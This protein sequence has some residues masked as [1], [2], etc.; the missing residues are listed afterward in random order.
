VH[1]YKK[2]DK[3]HCSNY[4]GISLVSTTYKILSN[5]LL[6]TLTPYAEEI[7]GDHQCG[8]Q[9]NRS[10]TVHIFCI[11]QILEKKW[12]YNEVVH[13]LFVDFKKAYDSIRREILY[14]I[15]IEFVIS[16]KLV[17]LVKI[18]LN[19]TYSRVWEGKHLS[20]RFPIKNGLK[21]GEALSPLL[22]NF[23]LEYAI[24]RVQAN[25]KGSKLN[26]MHQLLVYANDVDILGGSIHTIRKNTD[27]LLIA[28]KEIGFEAN[29][30]KT[31][32]MVMS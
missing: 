3:T 26:E 24:W 12:Q 6:S 16:L 4:C 19:E 2:G 5:I 13:Q 30:E 27:A 21:Q 8:F 14:N 9:R 25:Q 28:S 20:E 7:I 18:C 10:T 29:A 1:V 23:A 32:Y 31:K 11:R 22:F 17:R 15:L